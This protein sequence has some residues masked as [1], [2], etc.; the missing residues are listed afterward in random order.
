LG[1]AKSLILNPQETS[2]LLQNKNDNLRHYLKAFFTSLISSF[3]QAV[4]LELLTFADTSASLPSN[5]SQV[6]VEYILDL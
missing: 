3:R 1:S 5:S 6:G 2:F 4:L